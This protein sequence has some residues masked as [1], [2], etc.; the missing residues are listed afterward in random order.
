MKRESLIGRMFGRLEVMEL[1]GTDSKGKRLWKCKC[2]CGNPE[3]T[4]VRTE[5]L[6][7]GHIKSCGCLRNEKSKERMTKHGLRFHDDY[8]IWAGM[9]NRCNNP[10]SEDYK[11]YGGR[12][13]S[14][15]KEWEDFSKFI[16]DMGERPGRGYSIERIDGDGNYCKENCKWA[17]QVEQSRNIAMKSNNTSGVTGVH[18]TSTTSKG[19]TYQSWVATWNSLDGKSNKK[20]FS[21]LKYGYEE[22]KRLAI[23]YR[24]TMIEQLNAQGAGY[25]N[26]HGT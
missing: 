8:K 22:A 2:S 16:E 17:L 11:Y 26:R 21:V 20:W 24:Q 25:S 9:R 13:I 19:I 15:C 23:E 5:S 12:G 3:F 6:N 4:A 14:V 7:S 10:N 18:L 1:L